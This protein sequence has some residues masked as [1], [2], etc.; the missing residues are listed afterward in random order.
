VCLGAV[1]LSLLTRASTKYDEHHFSGPLAL[2]MVE[3]FAFKDSAAV[4]GREYLRSVPDEADASLLVDLI[5]AHRAGG[6]TSLIGTDI[7]EMREWLRKQQQ[8]DF[9]QGHVVKVKGWIL[10]V[11]EA[12]LSALAALV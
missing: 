3:F 5:C 10:S 6:R 1:D 12:R 11:T 2:N 8:Q 4:V 7:V 9:E